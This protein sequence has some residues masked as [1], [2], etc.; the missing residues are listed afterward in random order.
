MTF[1]M[2]NMKY[3]K[4]KNAFPGI[5]NDFEKGNNLPDGRSTS[6]PF[7]KHDGTPDSNTQ[8]HFADGSPKSKREVDF[9]KRHEDETKKE[10]NEGKTKAL[11]KMIQEGKFDYE[12]PERPKTKTKKPKESGQ[13]EGQYTTYGDPDFY[14][15]DSG[16]KINSANVDE[17]ELSTVKKDKNGRRYVEK[18]SDVGGGKLYID[19]K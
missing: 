1:K 5:N 13:K 6:S 19:P 10:I 4:T 7:Q 9:S 11:N 17:G 18:S 16:K 12:Q 14:Y 15:D 3:W 2:K 8:T